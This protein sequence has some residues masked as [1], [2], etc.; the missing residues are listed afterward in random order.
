MKY[1]AV[2]SPTPTG[3]MRDA[4][5]GL[6]YEISRKYAKVL[7]EHCFKK[8]ELNLKAIPAF[9][10]GEKISRSHYTIW[11]ENISKKELFRRRLAG[12][13]EKDVIG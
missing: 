13:V 3:Y 11:G 4:N 6:T 7:Y 8:G 10:K 2:K 12:E 9:N 5:A 1:F